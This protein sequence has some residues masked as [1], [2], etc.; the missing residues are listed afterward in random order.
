MSSAVLVAQLAALAVS[1]AEA[2]VGQPPIVNARLDSAPAAGGLEAAVRAAV[3]KQSGAAWI[4]YAVP[5]I[6]GEGQ[7]CCWNERGKG[8]GLAGREANPATFWNGLPEGQRAAAPAPA[9][10]VVELEGPSHVSVLLRAEGGAIGKIRAYS[11][12]CPL[13]AGGLPLHWL[14]GVK[15]AESVALLLRRA[16]AEGADR[17]S[18]VE[19]AVH[20][21]AMHAGG[22]AQAALER[23]ASSAPLEQTRKSALFWLAAARG[24]AGYQ[25]V[26]RSARED[27]S[28]KVREHAIFALTQSKEPEAIPTIVRIAREDR[29]PR[30]RKQ[31]MFWLG[32]S[33]DPR[34][35]KFFEEVLSR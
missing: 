29:S 24:R 35:F 28:D 30:V 12:D 20:A 32:Q 8:C 25:A 34:A 14:T 6:P 5:R 13:D 27:P 23:L 10:R 9:P 3:G 17:K 18:T 22:E 31:A 1:T 4:G 7:A 16:D 2:P 21:L 26:S 15:P 33:R 19:P 11:S